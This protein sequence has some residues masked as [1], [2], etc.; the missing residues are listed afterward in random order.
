MSFS[1]FSFQALI[2]AVTFLQY[3]RD[4]SVSDKH[5]KIGIIKIY[6]IFDKYF[7]VS[8]NQES[9]FFLKKKKA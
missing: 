2:T 9:S 3:N 4:A 1:H 7:E 6:Q 8:Y 5:L